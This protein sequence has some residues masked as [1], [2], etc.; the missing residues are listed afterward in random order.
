M[1]KILS[2]ESDSWFHIEQSISGL[3]L[4]PHHP[5]DDPKKYLFESFYCCTDC[6]RHNPH[7]YW[8]T[9]MTYQEILDYELLHKELREK[10]IEL[11]GSYHDRNEKLRKLSEEHKKNKEEA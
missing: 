7:V 1:D 4:G 6:G 8:K 2:E 9:E 5:R 3:Y 10:F 11:I